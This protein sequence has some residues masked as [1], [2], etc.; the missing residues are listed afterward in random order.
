MKDL[1]DLLTPQETAKLPRISSIT[2]KRWE[3]KGFSKK[4]REQNTTVA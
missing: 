1:P 2:L 3:K 4:L